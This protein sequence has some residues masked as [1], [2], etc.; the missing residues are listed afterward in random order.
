MGMQTNVSATEV[1][2]TGAVYGDRTRVRS[3]TISYASGGTVVLSNGSGGATQFS[4]TAPAAAGTVH[5]LMPG[6]GILFTASVYATLTNATIT[7]C[8]G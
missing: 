8:Y 1:K 6:E 5:V 4:F 3:V 7:V 2:S